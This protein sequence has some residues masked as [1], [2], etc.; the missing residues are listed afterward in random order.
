[1]RAVIYARYSCDNQREESIE[2]QIRECTAY[3]QKNGMTVVA[4]YIDR[5]ESARTDRRPEFQ[6]MIEDS[7]RGQFD[8]IIVWKFDRF[9]RN[10]YVSVMYK[11]RLKKNNVKVLS[12]TENISNGPEGN[13]MEALL[14]AMDEYFSAELA[15]KVS[16]GMHENALKCKHNGGLPPFGYT[17]D[18]EKHYQIDPA[19]APFVQEI[20]NRYDS[21][22]MMKDIADELTKKG[23]R[24]PKGKLLNVNSISRILCNR[25]YIGEYKYGETIIP[26]SIP[27]IITKD[28][29]ERVQI[30]MEKNKRAPAQ[31]RA[32]D[33]YLL[34]TKLF[35]GSCGAMMVGECGTSAHK[36]RKYHYYRCVNTK[37]TKRVN[38]CSAKHKSVR[39]TAIEYAVIRSVMEKIMDDNFVE[40]IADSVMEFQGEGSP[41]LPGFEK[42]LRD[43][44][45]GI[46]NLLDALQAGIGV[47]D[48]KE[49]LAKLEDTKK[50]LQEQIALE[51]I[52]YP[53]LTRD[54][55]IYWMH[56]FRKLDMNELEDRRRLIDSFVNSVTIYDDDIV[57]TFNYKDGCKTIP[58]SSL[59]S[60]DM[61]ALGVPREVL[62][63]WGFGTSF[64]RFTLYLTLYPVHACFPQTVL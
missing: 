39:K 64:F 61:V 8:F 2:G 6:R 53:L 49:R 4:T 52:N 22:D 26:D 55:V 7:S 34:T 63:P 30:R 20:F 59:D 33:E 58:F 42:Q 36:K 12:A 5:A 27:A 13:L 47:D 16:R 28:Q 51:K 41:L 37:R 1:M 19:T 57:I 54:E 48:I 56:L 10:R 45:R 25:K 62:K 31:R 14:E 3:C 50:S 21:G 32:E 18:D 40:F 35:C 15:M 46:G 44:E 23:V 17:V 29:F 38:Q 9:A 43:T 60:S 24:G 11:S